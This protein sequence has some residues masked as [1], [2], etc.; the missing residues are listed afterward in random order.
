VFDK[1]L[2]SENNNLYVY[3]DREMTVV[4]SI[5]SSTFKI[6]IVDS[7]NK[8]IT[9]FAWAVPS[10]YYM[11]YVNSESARYIYISLDIQE[12]LG[13][14]DNSATVTVNYNFDSGLGKSYLTFRSV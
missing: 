7:E 13:G 8:E 14:G 11:E 6:Q 2:V 4:S 10:E 12:T 5:L 9:N 3:F 1:I